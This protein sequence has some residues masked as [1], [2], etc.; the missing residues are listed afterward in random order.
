M[1]RQMTSLSILLL[2]CAV[3][4]AHAGDPM[5]YLISDDFT[6][7][8]GQTPM[9]MGSAAA[10][11]CFLTRVQGHLDGAEEAVHAR[12]IDGDWVL[13]GRSRHGGVGANARCLNLGAANLYS[14]AHHWQQGEAAVDLGSAE[15]RACFLTHVQGRFEGSGEWVHVFIQEGRWKL[16]GGSQQTGVAAGARCLMTGRYGDEMA[17]RAG[18]PMD[19]M[20]RKTQGVCFLTGIQ[21]R[22]D[23]PEDAAMVMEDRGKWKLA[24]H[25][26]DHLVVT[27]ARCID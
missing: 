17:S 14:E 20:R 1:V 2:A 6:W 22:F 3:L 12:I 23:G 8:Q 10:R 26:P 13:D 19:T 24:S 11:V 25:D 15:D 16:D 4:P 18:T 7:Q 5:T 21:G 9:N 27:R